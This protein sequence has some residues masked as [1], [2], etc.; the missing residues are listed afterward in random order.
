MWKLGNSTEGGN[1]IKKR[2]KSGSWKREI[3]RNNFNKPEYSKN[4]LMH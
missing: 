3:S 1:K 2:I 4:R